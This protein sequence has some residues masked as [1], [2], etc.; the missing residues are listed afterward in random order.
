MA[1]YGIGGAVKRHAAKRSLQRPVDNHILDYE[2]M[3][4][5]CREMLSTNF[6]GFSK[7]VMNLFDYLQ[8]KEFPREVLC[9]TQGVAITLYPC[10][11]LKSHISIPARMNFI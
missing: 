6:S 2:A 1:I 5:V 7:N 9:Q 11:H 10:R 4:E 3:L 8:K